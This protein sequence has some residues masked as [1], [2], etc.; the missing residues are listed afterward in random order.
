MQT[1]NHFFRTF[2]TLVFLVSVAS[3]SKEEAVNPV[4]AARVEGT[5]TVTQIETAGK[6]YNVTADTKGTM[7]VTR[8]DEKTVNV[9]INITHP[10]QPIKGTL[11]NITLSDAGNGEVG[12]I[13]DGY[14]LG[15]GGN[16]KLSMKFVDTD[17]T[18][19]VFISTK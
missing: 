7:S 6:L 15:M 11:T 4:L 8:V 3:C 5:Y 17:G 10:T 18:N 19:F 16:N 2:F 14:N 9:A 12:L 1:I 13:K